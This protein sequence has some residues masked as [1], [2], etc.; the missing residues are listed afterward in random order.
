MHNG[1]KAAADTPEGKAQRWEEYQQRGG[2]WDYERWSN[3]YDAAI[4][5][6]NKGNAAADAYLDDL[7]WGKREVTV[8]VELNGKTV[9]RRL[10]I[11]DPKTQ[12]GVE[13]KSG[14]YFSRTEDIMYEI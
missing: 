8:D 11:A 3:T 14:D 7:G 4:Q 12:R 2:E 13:V 1:Y 9:N 10:D 6:A 5:N